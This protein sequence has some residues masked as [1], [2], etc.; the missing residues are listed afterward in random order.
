MHGATSGTA[1]DKEVE[2]ESRENIYEVSFNYNK[3]EYEYDI[4]AETGKIIRN[5]KERD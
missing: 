1:T 5:H 4:N 3:Y 2:L